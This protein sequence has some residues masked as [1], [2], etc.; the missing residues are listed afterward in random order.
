VSRGAFAAFVYAATY[1]VSS[2]HADQFRTKC[3]YMNFSKNGDYFNGSCVVVSSSDQEGR[4]I[5][6]FQAGNRRI[7]IVLENRQ[8]QWGQI[9]FNGKIGMSFEENRYSHYYS[10]SDLSE[11]L[12]SALTR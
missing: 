6:E 8:G 3:T 7:R 11:M 9:T 4:Y 10:P 1:I 2:A 12:E 5:E